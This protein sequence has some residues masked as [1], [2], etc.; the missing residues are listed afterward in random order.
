MASSIMSAAVF[1]IRRE[2]PGYSDEMYIMSECRRSSPLIISHIHFCARL[3]RRSLYM[4]TVE[5]S[6]WQAA[7]VCE[8]RPKDVPVLTLCRSSLSY[9][10]LRSTQQFAVPTRSMRC[11][12]FASWQGSLAARA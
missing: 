11:L 9:R 4:G 7:D 2:F 6:V 10:T 8:S 1:D 5:R 12:H 3:H